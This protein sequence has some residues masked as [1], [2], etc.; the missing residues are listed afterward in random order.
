MSMNIRYP[1][2]TGATEREQLFQMKSYLRQLVDQ[3]NYEMQT[4]SQD[5]PT[6]TGSGADG[7]NGKTPQKGVD[8]WT[9]ADV[10]QIVSETT[11]EVLSQKATF[12]EAAMPVGY[13]YTSVTETS[14]QTLFGFGTW[15]RLKDTFLLAAGDAYAAGTT[16]GEA[17]HTLTVNEMPSHNHPQ[18]AR[19]HGYSGWSQIDTGAG[20]T[21]N[22]NMASG[23][24]YHSPNTKLN[25]V[26]VSMGGTSTSSTGG[27]QPHNNMPPYTTVYV[28]KRTA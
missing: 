18:N 13:I 8:Y 5:K 20:Y 4:Q 27:S 1:N 11:A 22:I 7:K 16:G 17:K 3:L 10:Q 15:E 2:I 23:G 25:A 24:N 12:L 9:D 28:W 19:V 26:V 21:V 14:P 6:A